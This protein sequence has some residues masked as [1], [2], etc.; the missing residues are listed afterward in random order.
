LTVIIQS[1]ILIRIESFAE[2]SLSFASLSLRISDTRIRKWRKKNFLKQRWIFCYFRQFFSQN[3]YFFE[4]NHFKRKIIDFNT[5]FLT[6]CPTKFGEGENL[7]YRQYFLTLISIRI[8]IKEKL[9]RGRGEFRELFAS[10]N[11]KGRIFWNLFV[12]NVEANSSEIF[13][14]FY[15]ILYPTTEFYWKMGREKTAPRPA[16]TLWY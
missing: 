4:N 15:T 14:I 12:L 2:N 1:G 11:K 7:W 3:T 16:E 9:R 8:K 5:N 6:Q 10:L 13:I